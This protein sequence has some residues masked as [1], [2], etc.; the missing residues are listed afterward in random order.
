MQGSDC[1]LKSERKLDR[2]TILPAQ[3][4]WQLLSS[5]P[6]HR[7][8]R[9]AAESVNENSPKRL[10]LGLQILHRWLRG[11][12]LN[13]RPSGYEPDELPDCST[14]RHRNIDPTRKPETKKPPLGQTGSG[15]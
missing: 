5:I 15:F 2:G 4:I 3:A 8:N 13:Q 7:E 11:L 12:D 14:P 10:A 6:K 9:Q 1:F